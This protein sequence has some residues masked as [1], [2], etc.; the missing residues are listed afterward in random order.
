[1]AH[2]TPG[3]PSI[4]VYNRPSGDGRPAVVN[5]YPWD[6][7]KYPKYE[8]LSLMLHETIPGHHYEVF[9]AGQGRAGQSVR[10]LVFTEIKIVYCKHNMTQWTYPLY[11][12]R[13]Q[14]RWEKRTYHHFVDSKMT[15]SLW[16]SLV[17]CPWIVLIL[18][19][20]AHL[21]ILFK[22]QCILLYQSHGNFTS[23]L[24]IVY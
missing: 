8:L 20:V 2:T 1:M 17:I 19:C 10:Q 4:A 3:V 13:L 16:L 21:L 14:V 23:S 6:T 7:K 24:P 11:N 15:D 12:Y 22:S 9:I 18:R 5:L